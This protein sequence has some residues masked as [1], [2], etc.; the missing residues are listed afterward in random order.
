MLPDRV[1]MDSL[2]TVATLTSL[3]FRENIKLILKV[4]HNLQRQF[5]SSLACREKW[6]KDFGGWPAQGRAISGV[7]G[8]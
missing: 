5:A 7:G 1:D 4:S 2:Q 8:A 6:R 3:P